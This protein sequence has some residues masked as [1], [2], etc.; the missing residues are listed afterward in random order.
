M[1]ILDCC[2]QFAFTPERPLVIAS[3]PQGT[4][5]PSQAIVSMGEAPFDE[6][7]D[8]SKCDL[9]W[10]GK[11]KVDVVRHNDKR[12]KLKPS[13][14]ADLFD[15]LQQQLRRLFRGKDRLSAV[16]V[17]GDQ[18]WKSVAFESSPDAHVNAG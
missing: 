6:P 4:R 14:V 16:N 10:H 9:R 7:H 12:K 15:N 1:D 11:N 3:L 2:Q 18:G 8:P 5:P 13:F 17:G